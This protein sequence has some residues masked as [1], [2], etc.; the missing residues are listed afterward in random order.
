MLNKN[1]STNLIAYKIIKKWQIN[2]AKNKEKE[3]HDNQRIW[4]RLAK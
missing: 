3:Y 1:L 4:K 2:I